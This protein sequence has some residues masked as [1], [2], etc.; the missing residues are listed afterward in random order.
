MT[1]KIPLPKYETHRLDPKL[2]PTETITNKEEMED[3]YRKMM[4]IR[5]IEIACDECYKRGEIRGFCHL[6]DGE[7]ATA[8]GIEAGITWDDYLITAYREHGNAYLRGISIHQ[9]M[10]EMMAK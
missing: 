10:A 2:L 3:L 1:Y 8:T 5:R 9:I 4:T 6:Y 7:E